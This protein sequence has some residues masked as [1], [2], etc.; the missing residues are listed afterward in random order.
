MPEMAENAVW[1]SHGSLGRHWHF[2]QRPTEV[3]LPVVGR[4]NLTQLF[5]ANTKLFYQNIA[6]DAP[7]V[8]VLYKNFHN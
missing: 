3:L 8:L 4:F 5:F 7:E 6:T 2:G 1:P